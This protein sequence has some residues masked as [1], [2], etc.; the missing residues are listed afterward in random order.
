MQFFSLCEVHLIEQTKQDV[1]Q[2]RG[3]GVRPPQKVLLASNVFA[4]SIWGFDSCFP[5]NFV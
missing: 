4:P 1:S 3:Q 2:K 5:K